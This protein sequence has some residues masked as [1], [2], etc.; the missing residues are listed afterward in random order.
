ML[1]CSFTVCS[2]IRIIGLCTDLLLFEQTVLLFVF[3]I[4]N[5][6]SHEHLSTR[7]K[8]KASGL[9]CLLVRK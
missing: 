1:A 6:H 8:E 2:T 9:K 3:N 7:T 5:V 4:N